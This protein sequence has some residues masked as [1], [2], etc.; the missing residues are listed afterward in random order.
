M[1][2][3][4]KKPGIVSA[5][6]SAYFSM[7]QGLLH[8]LSACRP[9]SADIALG[10]LDIGLEPA[11]I[12]TLRTMHVHVVPAEWD[13]DFPSRA[14]APR[15]FQAMTARSR[16][17]KYFPDFDPIIWIDS[18]C[19]LQDWRAIDLLLE[20]AQTDNRLAVVPEID[21]CYR[22]IYRVADYDP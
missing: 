7:L 5:A 1:Q 18:D 8:S 12:E 22:H 3:Q 9:A 11:Q 14:T 21:R 2:G 17:P 20:A 15:W 10:V 4:C 16:L 6:D 19:W 13:Y